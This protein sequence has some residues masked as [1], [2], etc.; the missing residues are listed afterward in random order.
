[1]KSALEKIK[2]ALIEIEMEVL[3]DEEEEEETTEETEVHGMIGKHT[4][5]H[6]IYALTLSL[7]YL[8]FL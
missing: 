2:A 8:M 1:M 5:T 6:T 3:A 4:H 7:F